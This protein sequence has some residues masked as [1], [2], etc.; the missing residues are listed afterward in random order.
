[1][2]RLILL[3]L[4]LFAL[5]LL[6]SGVY[7]PLV[8]WLGAGSAIFAAV[9]VSR[10]AKLDGYR[11]MELIN[12]LR[13]VGYFLWLLKEIAVS[14]IAVTK[15]ILGGPD[16]TRQN[17]FRVPNTQATDLCAVIYANSITLTPGT[18]T[19]EIEEDHFWIHALSYSDD[20]IEAL[21][22]MDARVTALE[23]RS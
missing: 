1:M 21:A 6:M 14:N 19:V 3:S 7:K 13:F 12:P 17:L 4:G 15:V 18:L 11:A 5:W 23:P 16:A 9:M 2:L 22:D 10:M 20:D 8:I